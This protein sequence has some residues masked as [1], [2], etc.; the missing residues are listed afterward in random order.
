MVDSF[1]SCNLFWAFFFEK[2]KTRIVFSLFVVPFILYTSFILYDFSF[3]YS[4]QLF[5]CVVSWSV[6]SLF[7]LLVDKILSLSTR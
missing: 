6:Y 4:S 3:V 1:F 7:A 5:F 2:K